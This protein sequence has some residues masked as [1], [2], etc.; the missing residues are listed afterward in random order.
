MEPHTTRTWCK[1]WMFASHGLRRAP[2][3]SMPGHDAACINNMVPRF[4]RPTSCVQMTKQ[5]KRRASGFFSW[6]PASANLL[7]IIPSLVCDPVALGTCHCQQT[8]C[9]QPS[10]K[11]PDQQDKSQ[12]PC[13]RF[14]HAPTGKKHSLKVAG[15]QKRVEQLCSV[16]VDIRLLCSH[17]VCLWIVYPVGCSR[18][19]CNGLERTLPVR[20]FLDSTQV[21]SLNTAE[22]R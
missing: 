10:C 19:S 2:C 7:G 12:V 21:M 14:E 5:I 20:I 1:T 16:M 6:D 9:K 18:I 8:G 22:S 15:H 4:W 3:A 17:G 13:S 11:A